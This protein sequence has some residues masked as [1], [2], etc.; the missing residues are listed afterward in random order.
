MFIGNIIA[1]DYIDACIYWMMPNGL[2]FD[3]AEMM[4]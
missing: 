2:K 1:L 3:R 4:G